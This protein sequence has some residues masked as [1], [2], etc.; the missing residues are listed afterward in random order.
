MAHNHT[1]GSPY[2]RLI[3]RLNR[4]PQGAAPSK[5]LYDI[6]KI[7]MS[8]REAGLMAQLPI[9]PFNVAKAA[10]IWKMNPAEAQKVLDELAHRAILVDIEQNGEQIYAVPPRWQVSLNS[11]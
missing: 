8:E 6:L 10:E 11:R 7:L 9:K 5:L 3:D 1:H 2:S 4:F